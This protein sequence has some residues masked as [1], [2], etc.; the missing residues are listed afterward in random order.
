MATKVDS[1]PEGLPSSGCDM[2]TAREHMQAVTRNYITHPRVSEYDPQWVSLGWAAVSSGAAFQP[3]G[4]RRIRDLRRP[5]GFLVQCSDAVGGLDK[6][7][8]LQ[9]EIGGRT[10]QATPGERAAE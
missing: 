5:V 8:P 1:R 3:Q 6:G 10:A 9:E 4:K 7:P 2:G